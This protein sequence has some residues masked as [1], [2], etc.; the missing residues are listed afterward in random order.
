MLPDQ[1]TQIVDTLYNRLLAQ[2]EQLPASIDR[3]T[4]VSIQEQ[5]KFIVSFKSQQFGKELLQRWQY[6]LKDALRK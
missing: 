6:K 2:C 5:V 4:Y 3:E 1:Q